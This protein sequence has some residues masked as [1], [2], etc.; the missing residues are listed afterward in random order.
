MVPGDSRLMRAIEKASFHNKAALSRAVR[1]TPHSAIELAPAFRQ[2]YKSQRINAVRLA[3]SYAQSIPKLDDHRELFQQAATM[4][5]DE[6]KAL[7]E[8]YRRA[9]QARGVVHA[10][11]QLPRAQGRVLMNDFLMDKGK[12]VDR[13][14]LRHV[15]YWLRDAGEQIV[16]M[17]KGQRPK[18]P[19]TDSAVVDFFE[20]I[21]D[22]IVSAINSIVDAV[23]NAVKSLGQAIADVIT[24]AAN[25][26]ANLVK[27]LI[28]AG[29][30]VLDLLQAALETGYELVK[31]ILAGLA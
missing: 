25:D 20:D 24:W 30:S 22:D 17:E 19:D 1:D 23:T 2:V 12:K 5:G 8:G 16:R 26:V 14:S 29:K 10:I 11:G 15:L 31:K 27:A 3:E 9:G 13:D 4:S 18:P 28:D 7:I 21:A 6:R